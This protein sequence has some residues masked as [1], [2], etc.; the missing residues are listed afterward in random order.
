MTAWSGMAALLLLLANAFFVA[1]E[2]ALVAARRSRL[3]QLAEGGDRRAHLAL[4]SAGQLSLMLAGAQLGITM[5]SLGLG[6]VAEPAVGR[7]VEAALGVTGLPEGLEHSMAV[8]IALLVVVFFHM[9]VGEMA[10]KNIAIA[11]PERTALILAR[12]IVVYTTL[13]SPVIRAVNWMANRLLE[14]FGVP[15]TDELVTAHTPDELRALLTN[16]R[17]EGLVDDAGHRLL[18]GAL[19]F[20][21]RTVQSVMVPRPNVVALPADATPHH[22]QDLVNRSGHSR[23][24]VYGRDLDDVVGFVHAKALLEVPG[25]GWEMALPPRL[26]RQ[27][28][29]VAEAQRL[30][31][32]LLE[33]QRS[34]VH[35]AVVLDG[36]GHTRGIVTLEDVVEALVGDIRD[37]YDRAPGPQR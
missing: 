21:D 6:Y 12:P 3:E 28:L 33:M 37:E 18:T 25:R 31:E 20:G 30:P 29:V 34:G 7:V 10:P 1:A 15:P 35:F 4:R 36:S 13:F 19:G 23:F 2:F 17:Q 24:P 11:S 32:V 26:I 8:V 9:V 5:A 14:L 16:A 27:M 22:L